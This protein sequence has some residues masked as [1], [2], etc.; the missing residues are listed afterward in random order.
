MKKRNYLFVVM[1]LIHTVCVSQENLEKDSLIKEFSPSNISKKVGEITMLDDSKDLVGTTSIYNEDI[2][3]YRYYYE[4]KRKCLIGR[5]WIIREGISFEYYDNGQLFK[6]GAYYKGK[7][8][9][10]WQYFTKD[11]RLESEYLYDRKGN[12]INFVIYYDVETRRKDLLKEIEENKKKE[13]N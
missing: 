9:G 7:K 10:L 12:Q 11:G 2:L 13:K 6:L 4:Y 8:I 3:R 1:M 5:K